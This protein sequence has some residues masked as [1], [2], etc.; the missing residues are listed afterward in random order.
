[1]P[2]D[3]SALALRRDP[4]RRTWVIAWALALALHALA[5]AGLQAG[6]HWV[7]SPPQ[8]LE[9]EPIR[10]TFVQPPAATAESKGPTYF[11]ELPTDRADEAPEH[12]DFLS[13]VTSRARDRVPGGDQSL[14]RMSGVADAPSVAMQSGRVEPQPAGAP[15]EPA[16]PQPP[17]A[18]DRATAEATKSVAGGASATPQPRDATTPRDAGPSSK[19]FPNESTAPGN[20]DI[21]QE[22]MDNPGGNAGLTGDVSLSTTAWEWS[23]WIQRFGRRLMHHWFAPTAYYIGVLK[24]GGWTVV[25]ME[26][27][28]SGQVLRM[29]VLEEQGHPSLTNAATIALRSMSPMEKLPA[30]F[31]DKTLI[32]RVRLIY[33]KIRPR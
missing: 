13:N 3:V 21:R 17:G 23:P 1:M 2:A 26:I 18:E 28:P 30:N 7:P 15:A 11:T 5:V 24:E 27:A 10:L 33:P 4:G 12:A 6:R 8:A 9:P 32:L 25:E 29:D 22:E 16:A 19:D 14:P 20:S 31:P